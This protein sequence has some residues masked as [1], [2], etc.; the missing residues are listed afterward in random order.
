[1]SEHIVKF[2]WC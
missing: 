1:M 2:V